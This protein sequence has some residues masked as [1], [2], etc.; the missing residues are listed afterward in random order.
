[1]KKVLRCWNIGMLLSIFG[2]LIMVNIRSLNYF[3]NS[4]FAAQIILAD[5]INKTHSILPAEWNFSTE[6]HI[7]FATFFSAIL[8]WLFPKW[9]TCYIISNILT[10]I[11]LITVGG[12]L[13][14]KLGI[15]V[16]WIFFTLALFL[17]PISYWNLYYYNLG[18][19]YL[20]YFIYELIYLTLWLQ[21]RK[22]MNRKRDYIFLG[23]WSC[24]LGSMGLRY[25]LACMMPA[26]F[27]EGMEYLH[28]YN[29]QRC[30]SARRC[31]YSVCSYIAF[32]VGIFINKYVLSV[33]Y[34]VKNHGRYFVSLEELPDR[35]STALQRIVELFGYTEKASL[36]S[37]HGI[38]STLGIA[39]IIVTV[40]SVVY[41]W[42][43]EIYG[44]Y[45]KFVVCANVLNMFVL[46]FTQ[47]DDNYYNDIR[48]KY[49][50]LGIFLCFP[51]V[52]AYLAELLKKSALR[53]GGIMVLVSMSI[54]FNSLVATLEE[55]DKTS[56]NN[57]KQVV[58]YLLNRGIEN[59]YASFWNANVNVFY[60]D[61][62][63]LI[64]P[65]NNFETMEL[66]KH[67]S[68]S[69]QYELNQSVSQYFIWLTKEEEEKYG[70]K[71]S[72]IVDKWS[73]GNIT[74]YICTR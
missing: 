29:E 56:Y 48:G 6:I 27:I 49:F 22:Y 71:I 2:M 62:E 37:K 12:C 38:A 3:V 17:A 5:I 41:F 26:I 53:G 70:E 39:L 40:L 46:I 18:N 45:T 28:K 16:S 61:G 51:L 68:S 8:L 63:L 43:H 30:F 9:N 1:M 44:T 66:Q 13:C 32:G 47:E 59:G 52:S 21:A 64:S 19:E 11:V 14:R 69:R 74:I 31:F 35:V 73:V 15:R 25:V 10:Y 55:R 72:N 20:T 24:F 54:I 60:S 42:K 50:I 23:I 57:H 34:T 4:D 65:V 33:H 58:E 36:F 67:I 7:S